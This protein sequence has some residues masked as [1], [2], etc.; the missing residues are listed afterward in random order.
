MVVVKTK[1]ELE[2]MKEAGRISA[3]A[4]KEAGKAIEPGVSTQEIDDVVRKYIESNGA[5]PSFLGYGGFPASAC[6]SV[7]NVIIHGIPSK[8]HIIKQGDIVSVDVGANIN[9]YH[10][11]NAW[12]YPCG[13][14]SDEAKRLLDVTKES[15]YMAIAVAKIGARIGDIGSTVQS[16]VESNGY[17]VVKKFVGH[18]IGSKLH[19][20]PVVP[21]YGKKGHGLR[22][23]EGMTIAIEP[24]V[25][26][27]NDGV[28]IMKD[29]WT[30]VTT[31]GKLSAHFEN[32]IAITE[33]GPLILTDLS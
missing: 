7:N 23:T 29:G 6:V 3:G 5:K 30:A 2:I 20:D 32:T 11:D 14:I 12:T 28:N 24:M 4:L 26:A 13:D 31:D 15:L 22:L 21:N 16:Y 19:E 27:G 25:N 18:G 33:D 10:G 9:G 8:K 1:R 17:S